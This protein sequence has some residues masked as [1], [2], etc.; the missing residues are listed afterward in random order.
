MKDKLISPLAARLFEIGNELDRFD[1]LALT[2]LGAPTLDKSEL[3][4]ENRLVSCE[5]KTWFRLDYDGAVRLTVES[6]SLFVKGLC[7]VLA[8]IAA[9]SDTKTLAQGIGFADEC[10]SRGII[11]DARRRGLLSLEE[12]IK[13]YIAQISKER[14]NEKSN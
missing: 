2:A 1:F 9:L 11:N 5:T 10:F 4:E 8:E 6:D 3:C 7:V 12:K 13:K 14:P